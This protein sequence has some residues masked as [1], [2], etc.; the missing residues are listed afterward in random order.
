MGSVLEDEWW[1]WDVMNSGEP[2]PWLSWRL[3]QPLESSCQHLF[4]ATFGPLAVEGADA[5]GSPRA[6]PE[7]LMP[8]GAAKLLFSLLRSLP[9]GHERGLSY[10]VE[11]GA[12]KS[13]H[14]KERR[15][16]FRLNLHQPTVLR[17]LKNQNHTGVSAWESESVVWW[18]FFSG[19]LSKT[20]TL[21]AYPTV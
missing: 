8:S 14:E 2:C 17:S 5:E 15:V 12:N 13:H 4:A 3:P 10:C 20:N 16:I 21:R 11:K 1:R 7:P 9:R 19:Y 6:H 18:A